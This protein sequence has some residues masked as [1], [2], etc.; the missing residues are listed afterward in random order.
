MGWSAPRYSVMSQHWGS[1]VHQHQVRQWMGISTPWTT[2]LQVG[3]GGG[4]GRS[5][6]VC[7][8]WSEFHRWNTVSRIGNGTGNARVPFRGGVVV[9]FIG[10]LSKQWDPPKSHPQ[11]KAYTNY[12]RWVYGPCLPLG[13]S[14]VGRRGLYAPSSMKKK[15]AHS[16]LLWYVYSRS[17]VSN[18]V[19]IW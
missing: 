19:D 18:E 8:S 7:T 12:R 6:F 5:V 1:P 15:Q 14:C 16:N 13:T 17:N 9:I 11:S 4:G 2:N 10:G 3:N